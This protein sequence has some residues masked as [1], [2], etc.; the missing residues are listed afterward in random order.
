MAIPG[1]IGVEYWYSGSAGAPVSS[2][3]VLTAGENAIR[4]VRN[5]QIITC[6]RVLIDLLSLYQINP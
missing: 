1:G 5:A 4:A 2:Y 3:P 6:G